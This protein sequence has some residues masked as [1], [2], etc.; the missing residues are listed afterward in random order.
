MTQTAPVAAPAMPTAPSVLA[1]PAPGPATE[2]TPPPPSRTPSLF[3]RLQAA[4]AVALVVLGAAAALIITGLRADVASAPALAEQYARL[5]QVHGLLIEADTLTTRSVLQR[6]TAEGRNAAEAADARLVRAAGLLVQ[7]AATRPTDATALAGVSQSVVAYGQQLRAASAAGADTAVA[8]LAAADEVLETQ[9]QPDLEQLQA[10]L[11]AQSDGGVAEQLGWIMPILAIAVTGA[12]VWMGWV[13]AQRTHRAVNLGLAGAL[14]AALVVAG[15]TIAAQQAAAGAVEASRGEALANVATISR[16]ATQLRTSEQITTRAA[17]LQEWGEDQATATEEALATTAAAV[18][19]HPSLPNLTAYREANEQ[20]IS[21][22]EASDWTGATRLVVATGNESL[23]S[24]A[25]EWVTAAAD[26]AQ[27]EVQSAAEAP[28]TTNDTLL[29]QLVV[30]ILAAL[31]GA[32][33]AV[34]GFAQR[35]KEYR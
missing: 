16:G 29:V 4:A 34:T 2:F 9:L 31:G 32:A 27:D 11:T 35:L 24:A 22:L 7:A 15:V 1:V 28:T 25:E 13:L 8:S 3:R 21:R 26:V 33:L 19:Q 18:N 12:L 23:S 10:R 5:G 14:V 6:G 17:L 30:A 20:V